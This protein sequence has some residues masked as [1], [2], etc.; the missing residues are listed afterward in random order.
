MLLEDGQILGGM[1]T[2]WASL[3]ADGYGRLDGSQPDNPSVR[4]R[5]KSGSGSRGR[6]RILLR[7][8]MVEKGAEVYSTVIVQQAEVRRGSMPHASCARERRYWLLAR[9]RRLLGRGAEKDGHP[10][11]GC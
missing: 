2:R 11:D 3:S 1:L 4:Q 5:D 10:I 7:L 9:E 8:A 6:L